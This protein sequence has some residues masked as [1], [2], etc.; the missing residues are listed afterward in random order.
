MIECVWYVLMTL[1]KQAR[2][3]DES[4]QDLQF[5]YDFLPR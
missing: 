3:A 1:L 5:P 4:S 2:H